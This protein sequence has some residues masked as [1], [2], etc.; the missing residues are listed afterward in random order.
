LQKKKPP[1]PQVHPTGTPRGKKK[2]ARGGNPPP[3]G[4][5]FE[6]KKSQKN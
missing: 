2:V 6:M 4:K 1:L 5:I 3:E